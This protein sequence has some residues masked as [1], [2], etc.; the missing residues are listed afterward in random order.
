[1]AISNIR[2]KGTETGAGPNTQEAVELKKKLES[3]LK[4]LDEADG[5]DKYFSVGEKAELEKLRALLEGDLAALDHYLKTGEWIPPTV[6]AGTSTQTYFDLSTVDSGF[7]LTDPANSTAA[8]V[9]P[10]VNPN[11]GDE[12]LMEDGEEYMGTISVDNKGMIDPTTGEII[13]ANLWFVMTSS[14]DA[15]KDMQ[16][17]SARTVGDDIVVTITFRDDHKESYVI[18]GGATR[19]DIQICVNALKSTHG[20]T[21]DLSRLTI[22]DPSSG[23][24]NGAIVIGSKDGDTIYGSTG[25]DV[26]AGAGGADKMDGMG[27]VDNVYGYAD[28]GT[29][30]EGILANYGTEALGEDGGDTIF[31]SHA[32]SSE[33]SDFIDGGAG[34]D[35]VV[36]TKGNPQHTEE[37][38]K[39]EGAADEVESWFTSGNVT[40]KN[41]EVVVDGKDVTFTAEDGWMITAQQDPDNPNDLLLVAVKPGEEGEPPVSQTIRIKGYFK[42]NPRLTINGGFV[43]MSGV[44]VGANA[45]ILNGTESAGDIL[46][47]PRTVFDDYGLTIEDLGSINLDD[48]TVQERLE[49]FKNAEKDPSSPWATADYDAATGRIVFTGSLDGLNI[50][51]DFS[52]VAFVQKEGNSYIIT[53]VGVDENGKIG[54]R[55]VLEVKIPTDNF[56]KNLTI[57]GVSSDKKIFDM[58]NADITAGVA[59]NGG[60]GTDFLAGYEYGTAIKDIS[61]DLGIEIDVP[62]LSGEKLTSTTVKTTDDIVNEIKACTTFEAL[63]AVEKKY[64]DLK[65]ENIDMDKVKSAINDTRAAI[66]DAKLADVETLSADDKK[67]VE[68][69][70]AKLNAAG[71]DQEKIKAWKEDLADASK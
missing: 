31:D 49:Y 70:I 35:T 50:P 13:P 56:M 58:R 44:N 15:S 7:Y 17:L 62:K 39:F 23:E 52:A 69:A 9:K 45:V 6:A 34:W 55:I 66:I 18:K 40:T 51:T 11:G 57:N 36:G 53:V 42:E 24:K 14:D 26:L 20:V 61:G 38:G 64:I 60:E 48:L 19:K 21:I 46:L 65:D 37:A 3:A 28:D 32:V 63:D 41:G 1:M 59:I 47:A 16:A 71:Y 43:D 22:I 68:D 29:D 4:Q 67:K 25:D 2:F 33:T 30:P 27:G 5:Y 10:T 8:P 54:E 12:D